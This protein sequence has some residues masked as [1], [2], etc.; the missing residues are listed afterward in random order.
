M[1]DA[2]TGVEEELVREATGSPEALRADVVKLGHHGS[3]TSTSAAF[4]D[5]V[6]PRAVLISVG[7]HNRFGHPA[8]SVLRRLARRGVRV[9]RTD[10]QGAIGIFADA[11][12]SWRVAT[13]R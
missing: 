12:G 8:P 10:E 1:G 11:Q 7:R 9:Y 6:R 5:A 4:L 2:P 13:T 3:T